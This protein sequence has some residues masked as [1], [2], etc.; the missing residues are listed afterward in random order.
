MQP[1]ELLVLYLLEQDF[2]GSIH[3]NSHVGGNSAIP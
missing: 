2:L 3:L 1:I